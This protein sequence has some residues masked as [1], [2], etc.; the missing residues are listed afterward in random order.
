VRHC[1]NFLDYRIYN[2]AGSTLTKCVGGC[3]GYHYWVSLTKLVRFKQVPYRDRAHRLASTTAG[4]VLI[5]HTV[6]V[7][8]KDLVAYDRTASVIRCSPGTTQISVNDQL[9]WRLNLVWSHGCLD[10]AFA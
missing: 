9:L 1:L 8:Y 6:A 7:H 10:S 2:H 4:I 3:Y 5:W